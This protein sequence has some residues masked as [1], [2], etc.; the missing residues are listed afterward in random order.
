MFTVNLSDP[1]VELRESVVEE[2]VGR[3]EPISQQSTEN[4]QKFGI[5]RNT[6]LLLKSVY[7]KSIVYSKESRYSFRIVQPED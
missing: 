4:E 3:G 5:A 6:Y 1:G 7:F 2:K